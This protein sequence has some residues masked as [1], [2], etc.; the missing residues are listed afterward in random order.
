MK[1]GIKL[2]HGELG[3]GL[4]FCLLLYFSVCV[5]AQS[6]TCVVVTL[7]LTDDEQTGSHIVPLFCISSVHKMVIGQFNSI[8]LLW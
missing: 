2:A 3:E 5:C 4:C 6:S 7:L 1:L 8:F